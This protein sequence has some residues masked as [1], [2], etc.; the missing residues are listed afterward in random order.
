[1]GLLLLEVFLHCTFNLFNR[2]PTEVNY[3]KSATKSTLAVLN[4][5]TETMSKTSVPNNHFLKCKPHR[6][7]CNN[8]LTLLRVI[9]CAVEDVAS[10]SHGD[11]QYSELMFSISFC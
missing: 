6:H 7:V 1:M 10:L 8:N 9:N 3:A 4:Y 11:Y 5:R 2:C